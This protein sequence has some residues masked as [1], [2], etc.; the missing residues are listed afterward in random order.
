LMARSDMEEERR[1]K[2]ETGNLSQQEEGTAKGLK[3][4]VLSRATRC[5]EY[6]GVGTPPD[7]LPKVAPKG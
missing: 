4:K 2:L 1:M 5:R 6:V 3:A 7:R